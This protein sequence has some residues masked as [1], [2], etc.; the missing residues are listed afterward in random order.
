MSLSSK[1]SSMPV[2]CAVVLW[3]LRMVPMAGK[4]QAACGCM[5]MR[6]LQSLQVSLWVTELYQDEGGLSREGG[7]G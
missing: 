3:W 6:L 4:R 5:T 7:M 2:P 1:D